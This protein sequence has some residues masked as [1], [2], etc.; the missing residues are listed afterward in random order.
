MPN[1]SLIGLKCHPVVFAET[2]GT[3]LSEDHA[4]NP[5]GVMSFDFVLVDS[6]IINKETLAKIREQQPN[7]K[8]RLSPERR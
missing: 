6:D 4:A 5:A 3:A 1:V 7:A 2:T 8:V